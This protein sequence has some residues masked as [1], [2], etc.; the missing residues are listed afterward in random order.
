MQA[1][2]GRVYCKGE[3]GQVWQ[4]TEVKY[5]RMISSP[6][7]KKKERISEERKSY[8]ERKK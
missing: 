5:Q 3:Q 6:L 7:K 1:G 4:G 2:R 8:K